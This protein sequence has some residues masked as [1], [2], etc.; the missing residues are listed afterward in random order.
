MLTIRV[1]DGTR[2]AAESRSDEAVPCAKPDPV[3][4]TR[5]EAAV[6]V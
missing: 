1:A 2:H 4:G 6:D 5:R 3:H